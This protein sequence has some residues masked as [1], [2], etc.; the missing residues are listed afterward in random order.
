MDGSLVISGG[1]FS[2]GPF[3]YPS[4]SAPIKYELFLSKNHDECD[5]WFTGGNACVRM[6]L[7]AN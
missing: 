3:T 4:G 1:C 2:V 7:I 5:S 6:K